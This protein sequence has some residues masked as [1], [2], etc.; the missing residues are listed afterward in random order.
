MKIVSDEAIAFQV[1]AMAIGIY[2]PEFKDPRRLLAAVEAASKPQTPD[3]PPPDKLMTTEAVGKLLAMPTRQVVQLIHR[4]KLPGIRLGW[5]TYR[6]QESV[7]YKLIA[8]A[9]IVI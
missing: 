3:G 7:V 2:R 4:G 1:A 8:D 9:K 6:V 5:K